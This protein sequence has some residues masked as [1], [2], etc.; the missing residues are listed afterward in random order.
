M[1]DLSK[2][3]DLSLLQI[4][5]EGTIVPINRTIA[6]LSLGVNALADAEVAS[7]VGANGLRYYNGALQYATKAYVQVTPTGAE[8]PAE[9]GWYELVDGEYEPTEDAAI[10]SGK[11][12]Y[13]VVYTWHTIET[14]GGGDL[15]ELE[16]RVDGCEQNILAL[17]LAVA[18]EQGA[19]I[20][21]TSDNIVVEVFDSTSGY[22]I[23]SG[24]YD[25]ENH[26][27]YA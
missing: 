19:E 7:E 23:A 17:V 16:K 6:L 18:I 10:V 9:Q 22:I 12:Y 3:I 24:M 20:D 25:S 2:L 26:R 13:R 27:V 8:N 1:A 11:N 5:G 14:G 15:T 21:G 4:F